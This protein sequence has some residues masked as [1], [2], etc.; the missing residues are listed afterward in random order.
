MGTVD[1]NGGVAPLTLTSLPIDER[2]D[3]LML[4]LAL[5]VCVGAWL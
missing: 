3:M 5:G 1:P 2:R 4:R